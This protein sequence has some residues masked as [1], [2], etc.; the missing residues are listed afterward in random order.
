[1]RL[2]IV[3]DGPYLPVLRDLAERLGVPVVF[4]GWLDKS[5]GALRDL[6]ETSS[7]FVHPSLAENFPTVVLEAMLAGLPII[8]VEGTGAAEL[9]GPGGMQVPPV[10]VDRLRSAVMAL[11]STPDQQHS[12]GLA[13]RRLAEEH[14]AWERVAQQYEAEMQRTARAK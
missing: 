8:A 2:E 9:A 1:Y 12:I 4:H 6:Y 11:G 7:I 10:D 3:G 5:N 14:F 13:G